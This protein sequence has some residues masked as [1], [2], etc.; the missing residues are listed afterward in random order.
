MNWSFPP[1]AL[2]LCY[3]EKSFHYRVY[4]VVPNWMLSGEG[5]REEQIYEETVDPVEYRTGPDAPLT[6]KGK[7]K[8]GGHDSDLKHRIETD[9]FPMDQGEGEPGDYERWPLATG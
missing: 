2:S 8:E 3:R 6:G 4:Q 1:F 9:E 7:N 5:K